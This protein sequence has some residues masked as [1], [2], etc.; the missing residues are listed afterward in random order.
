MARTPTAV[1]R[2]GPP[3]SP[4]A[5][6][7]PVAGLRRTWSVL[8][9][10]LLSGAVCTGLLAGGAPAA[11]SVHRAISTASGQAGGAASTEQRQRTPSRRTHS[12]SATRVV[13]LAWSAPQ[14]VAGR[15]SGHASGT[16]HPMPWTVS[17]DRPDPY[18]RAC[19]TSTDR[20]RTGH[21]P[22]ALG[23]TG[24]RAPPGPHAA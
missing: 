10:L 19:D 22:A 14:T 1:S 8:A 13:H 11:A 17:T 20:D 3:A 16:A 18:V 2:T 7:T 23:G 9:G 12:Q 24:V 4:P 21:P 15:G 5:G 6:R